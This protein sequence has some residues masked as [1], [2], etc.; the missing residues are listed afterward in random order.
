MIGKIGDWIKKTAF[1]GFYNLT[2]RDIVEE[3]KKAQKESEKDKKG[4]MGYADFDVAG[5]LFFD[6]QQAGQQVL[7]VYT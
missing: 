6:I 1:K 3:F 7:E 2:V 4:L 5:S